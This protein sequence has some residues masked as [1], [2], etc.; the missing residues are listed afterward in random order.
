MARMR[1]LA[2][3]AAV[4]AAALAPS[5]AGAAWTETATYDVPGGG[6]A[7]CL[8]AAGTNRL[9]LLG[10]LGRI[11]TPIDLLEMQ[12]DGLAPLATSTLGW[13]PDCPEIATA[14]AAPTLAAG[15]IL[16]PRGRGH[17][18]TAL[19]VATLGEAP[20]TLRPAGGTPSVATA[21]GGA[22]IVAG[23]STDRACSRR[24]A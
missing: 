9:A 13:L 14:D 18:A 24:R 2:L 5:A 21:P 11:S 20:Q 3:L 15:I 7:D 1:R 12:G 16:L 19:R 22:A 17:F 6:I 23:S 4:V 10:S 8:R